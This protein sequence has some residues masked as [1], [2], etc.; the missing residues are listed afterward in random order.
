MTLRIYILATLV[1]GMALALL[2]H[3]A[4]VW[5]LREFAIDE[6]NIVIL[7]AETIMMAGIMCFSLYCIFRGTRHAGLVRNMNVSRRGDR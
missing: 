4:S 1:L 3:F 2:S 6:P 7:S 5:T